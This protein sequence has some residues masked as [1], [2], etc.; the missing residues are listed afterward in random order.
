MYEKI[1][2]L[3]CGHL[4]KNYLIESQFSVFI[5]PVITYVLNAYVMLDARCKDYMT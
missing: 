2:F 4:L 3:S 1:L 5:E